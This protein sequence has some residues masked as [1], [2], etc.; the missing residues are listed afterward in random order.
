MGEGGQRHAPAALLTGKARYPLYRRMSG[1]Q[2]RSGL[3]RKISPPQGFDP[4]TV[5]PVAS[6]YTYCAFTSQK[7]VPT[8]QLQRL[9]WLQI[10][11]VRGVNRMKY[12]HSQCVGEMRNLLTL[13]W[14]V[15]VVTTVLQR[16]NQF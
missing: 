1:P 4:R 15:Y 7:Y 10:F 3:M 16:I 8:S 14:V 6:R 11:D 9:N 2:G 12:T 13:K 5:Q